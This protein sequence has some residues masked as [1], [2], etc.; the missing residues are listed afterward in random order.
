MADLYA[1]SKL[2]IGRAG[3]VAIAEYTAAGVPA[4]CLPYPHHKDMHQYLNAKPLVNA[5][6]G[7]I[8]DDIPT[9][10][11]KTTKKLT[12][13]ILPLMKNEEK[14]N[15]MAAAAKDLATPDAAKN[16]AQKITEMIS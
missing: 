15:E 6:A 14:R 4:I 9:D 11:L 13:Y 8:V 10:S 3:A 12:E 2:L 1:A 7:I 16:I 5:G